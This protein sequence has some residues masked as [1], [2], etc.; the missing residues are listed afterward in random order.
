[1]QRW[2]VM[3]SLYLNYFVFAILLN[4]VGMVILEVR[5]T[6]GITESTASVPEACKDLPTGVT[7]FLAASFI[8]LY[9]NRT[10]TGAEP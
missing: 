2:L 5:N 6:C 4:S 7:S 10:M 9:Q 3:F 1:M 8:L